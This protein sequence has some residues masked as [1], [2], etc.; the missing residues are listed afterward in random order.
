VNVFVNNPGT[1]RDIL[2]IPVSLGS[3]GQKQEEKIAIF[4]Y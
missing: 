1:G 4:L 3:A 2:N